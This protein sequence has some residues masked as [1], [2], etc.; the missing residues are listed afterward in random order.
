MTQQE[1]RKLPFLL[2]RK[3]FMQA[4]GLSRVQIESLKSSGDI[5]VKV[6]PCKTYYRSKKKVAAQKSYGK[7]FKLDAARLAGLTL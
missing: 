4:T 2:T 6:F 7:Y 1:F 5:R 3:Q